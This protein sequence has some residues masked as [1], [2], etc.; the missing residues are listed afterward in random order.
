MM[1]GFAYVKTKDCPC[2][3]TGSRTAAPAA[4]G[5]PGF[6]SAT[7]VSTTEGGG[8]IIWALCLRKDSLI[9]KDFPL[10]AAWEALT[11]KEVVFLPPVLAPRQF[12]KE[13]NNGC[14]R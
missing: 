11:A 9:T 7:I 4:V 13:G 14:G 3:R 2:R 8:E 5:A 10:S 12:Q 1:I 6:V